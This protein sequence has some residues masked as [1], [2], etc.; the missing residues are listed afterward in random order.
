MVGWML[1]MRWYSFRAA[2]TILLTICLL[3]F[4]FPFI[5]FPLLLFLQLFLPSLSHL[6]FSEVIILFFL[7]S[8]IPVFV[9]FVNFVCTCVHSHRQLNK[10]WDVR[11]F[12]SHFITWFKFYWPCVK[13]IMETGNNSNTRAA[14]WRGFSAGGWKVP[15]GVCICVRGR[16]SNM[17]YQRME[18]LVVSSFVPWLLSQC[19]VELASRQLL[20]SSGWE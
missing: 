9:G 20:S 14:A 13:D 15:C 10:G 2:M 12:G 3:T 19:R 11:L 5:W 1:W 4:H 8:P 18:G 17:Y 16:G 6:L 7:C